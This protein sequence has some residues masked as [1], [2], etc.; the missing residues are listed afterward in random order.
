MPEMYPISTITRKVM[1]LPLAD[2][3][4]QD[5]AIEKGQAA[6]KQISMIIAGDAQMENWASFDREGL[7]KDE[8]QVLRAAHHGSQNG[9][10]WERI[11]RLSPNL[12][13]VSSD[14]EGK[15]HLPDL[16]S[17]AV[18]TKF[19]STVEVHMRM[20]VDPRHADQQVRGV[21]LMPSGTGKEVRILVFAEGDAARIAEEA[22]AGNRQRHLPAWRHPG[23]PRERCH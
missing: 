5:F 17:T 13:V 9:T 3:D 21:V 12:V 19:D 20:G 14:P 1:L 6:P 10:Q 18:F 7:L 2:R 11:F 16:S 15:D 22:G 4:R 8:C 23:Q